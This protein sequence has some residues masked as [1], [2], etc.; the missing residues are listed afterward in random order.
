MRNQA[1]LLCILLGF[2][3]SLSTEMYGI[4]LIWIYCA[5]TFQKLNEFDD[6]DKNDS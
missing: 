6:D 2:L 1:A 5:I 4:C 3:Y